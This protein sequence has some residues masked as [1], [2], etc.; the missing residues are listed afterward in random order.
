MLSKHVPRTMEQVLCLSQSD[1]C[2]EGRIHRPKIH[3]ID[4]EKTQNKHSALTSYDVPLAG[5]YDGP[6]KATPPR[7]VAMVQTS[8]STSRPWSGQ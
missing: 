4:V 5:W 3:N 2:K 7:A 8:P 1:I 6:G